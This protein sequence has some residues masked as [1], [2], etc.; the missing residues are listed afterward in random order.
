M[1]VSCTTTWDNSGKPGCKWSQIQQASRSL[2]W[3]L[4]SLDLVQIMM[5]Q[6]FKQR[7]HRHGEV[8]KVADP[9]QFLV[10]GAVDVHLDPERV[11]V[12]PA[13]LCPGST[14]GNRSATSKVNSLK[15]STRSLGLVHLGRQSAS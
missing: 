4:Q 5:V 1:H 11:P 13:H 10:D 14:F 15:M 3:V 12:Q 6:L 9:A 8:S 7:L 2:V